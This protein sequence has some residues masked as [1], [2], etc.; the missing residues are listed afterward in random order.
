MVRTSASCAVCL[1]SSDGGRWCRGTHHISPNTNH[2]YQ[3]HPFL[4][5]L[6]PP[7]SPR[8]TPPLLSPPP[9]QHPTAPPP[10]LPYTSPTCTT[11]QAV[12]QP[13]VQFDL[14]SG[15]ERV[16]F[17]THAS[18]FPSGK[19]A[20]CTERKVRTVLLPDDPLFAPQ[21]CIKVKQSKAK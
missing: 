5:P 16:S 19:N 3:R 6:P 4:G 21:L 2:T 18:K 13:Y 14:T 11:M 12:S 8:C 10:L 9:L 17:T 1:Y 7:T 15:G 20:N